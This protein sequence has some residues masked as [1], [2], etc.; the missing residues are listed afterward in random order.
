VPGSP[1]PPAIEFDVRERNDRADNSY[2]GDRPAGRRHDLL[3][4]DQNLFEIDPH[5]IYKANVQFT[6]MD[7]VVRHRDGT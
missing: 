1:R 3:L 5:D 7:G 6:M 2:P 4:D